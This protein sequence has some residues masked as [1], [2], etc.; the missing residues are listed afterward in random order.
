MTHR[1][2]PL[3]LLMLLFACTACVAGVQRYPTGI[4][5]E[6]SSRFF[7]SIE[8]VATQEGYEAR[9]LTDSLS[10]VVEKKGTL[11][12]VL[13]MDGTSIDVIVFPEA[14]EGT[15]DDELAAIAG[16]LKVVSDELIEKARALSEKNKAFDPS[17][18]TQR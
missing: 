8:S 10:V 9:P 14:P 1:L 4:P 18:P 16:E 5:S 3:A 17:A 11:Q 15:S 2:R 12:Y 13:D 7:T 6:Q